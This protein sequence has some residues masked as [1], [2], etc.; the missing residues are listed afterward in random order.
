MRLITGTAYLKHTSTGLAKPSGPKQISY[1]SLPLSLGVHDKVTVLPSISLKYS[2]LGAN[3][4]VGRGRKIC[5]KIIYII[6]NVRI[7]INLCLV[8]VLLQLSCSQKDMLYHKI[9]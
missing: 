8:S 5:E 9:H 2:S 4:S 7:F 3:G 6:T 1:P